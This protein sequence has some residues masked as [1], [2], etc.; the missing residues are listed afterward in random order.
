MRRADILLHTKYN[1]PCPTVVLEALASGLPVVYSASGGL[2]E[3]VAADA[4]VGIP[5]PLDWERDYPPAPQELAGAALSLIDRLP[6]HAEAARAAAQRF[7]ARGWIE[8]HRA[9]FEQLLSR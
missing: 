2:P 1:D 9:V 4:G 7:D 3:L 8:R 5:A 6:E